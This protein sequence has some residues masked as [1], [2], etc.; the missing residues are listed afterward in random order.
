MSLSAGYAVVCLVG[1]G[2]LSALR[3]KVFQTYD[4]VVLIEMQLD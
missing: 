3:V 1:W 4:D 2:V